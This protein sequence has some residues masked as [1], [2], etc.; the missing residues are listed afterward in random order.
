MISRR[1][2]AVALS[3]LAFAGC[4]EDPTVVAVAVVPSVQA[5]ALL[6]A[7]GAA[8]S[9]PGTD[10]TGGRGGDFKI[11]TNGL[12]SLG[13]PSFVPEVPAVPAAPTVFEYTAVAPQATITTTGSILV[14]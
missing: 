3:L 4:H 9:A 12:V 6:A 14:S 7:G 2:A 1:L 11:T 10:G 5:L 8:S 13:S